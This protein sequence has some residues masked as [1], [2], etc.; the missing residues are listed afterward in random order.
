MIVFLVV[1]LIM[2]IVALAGSLAN[3]HHGYPRRPLPVSFRQDAIAAAIT[4]VL[5]IW[6]IVLLVSRP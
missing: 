3:M 4:F 5:L 2:F 6:T 1:L